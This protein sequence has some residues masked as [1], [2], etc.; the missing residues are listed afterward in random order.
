MKGLDIVLKDVSYERRALSYD[1]PVKTG[2]VGWWYLGGSLERSAVNLADGY[3]DATIIGA[4]TVSAAYLTLKSSNHYLR[5]Q[6]RLG[7]A[8]TLGVVAR[9][10]DT[11]AAGANQPILIGTSGE[12]A[13]GNIYHT[14]NAANT[15]MNSFQSD[16][17]ETQTVAGTPGAANV[18]KMIIASADA[19]AQTI[20]NM[21]AGAAN[22]EP[23]DPVGGPLIPSTLTVGIGS[24]G[25]NNSFGGT[26]QIAWACIYNRV[27]SSGERTAI[28]DRVK[29]YLARRGITG[30]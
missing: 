6:L 14:S 1:L 27:L 16:G 13:G 24:G 4:P 20:A 29:A 5:T 25:Q 15:A 23:Q 8:W 9:T 19:A 11:L 10:D 22:T 26:S 2:C 7:A 28:Y 17:A 30:L 21:S 18:W 3:P 12:S